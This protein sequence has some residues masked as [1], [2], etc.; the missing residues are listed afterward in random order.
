LSGGRFQG[1]CLDER[2]D[3]GQ[4]LLKNGVRVSPQIESDLSEDAKDL[5]K[6]SRALSD[7]RDNLNRSR[8]KVQHPVYRATKR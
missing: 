5:A 6:R 3:H 7:K 8:H 4:T 2:N 1:L